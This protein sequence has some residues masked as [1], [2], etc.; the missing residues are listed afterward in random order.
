MKTCFTAFPTESNK[1]QGVLWGPCPLHTPGVGHPLPPGGGGPGLSGHKL[2]VGVVAL[3]VWGSAWDQ[4]TGL[5]WV[6]YPV[7]LS[8]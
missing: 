8:P 5:A 7:S 6:Q 1:P 3:T 2:L 4:Y